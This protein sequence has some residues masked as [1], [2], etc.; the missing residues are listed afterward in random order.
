MTSWCPDASCCLLERVEQLALLRACHVFGMPY[1]LRIGSYSRHALA[2]RHPANAALYTFSSNNQD[3]LQASRRSTPP[4]ITSEQIWYVPMPVRNRFWH[5]SGIP[6]RYL[7]ASLNKSSGAWRCIDFDTRPCVDLQGCRCSVCSRYV[8][9][10]CI[11]ASE[12]TRP[13]LERLYWITYLRAVI[14][15]HAVHAHEN[16]VSEEERK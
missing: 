15:R 5:A 7:R 6:L 12:R 14:S 16:E 9:Q 8:H 4:C 13:I 2:E 1:H 10:K 3:C 11:I